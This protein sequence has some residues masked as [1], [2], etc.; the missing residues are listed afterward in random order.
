MKGW[1][2]IIIHPETTIREAMDVIDRSSV[3]IALVVDR[4]DY[5][6]GTLTDGDMRRGLLKGIDLNQPVDTIYNKSPIFGKEGNDPSNI[7]AF[8][9]KSC[10]RQLPVLDSEGRVVGF[11]LLEDFLWKHEQKTIVVLMAGGLGTR[12]RPLTETSPKPLLK[13]GD[14]PLLE[15]TLERFVEL[16]FKRF[17]VAVNYMAKM[18]EE[19]FGDGS[20]WG[21]EIGYLRE[22]KRLGTAGALSLLPERP[23]EPSIVIN[24]DLLT[25]VN[26]K[27]LLDFHEEAKTS[28]TICVRE[29]S[30]RIPFGV[31]SIE[32]QRLKDLE[33]KPTQN[34][35]VNA[36]I[37]VLEP[38]AIDLIPK[39]RFYDMTNLFEELTRLG[40]NPAVFPLREYWLDIGQMV[41]Y[42]Q[43]NHEY[44]TS[45]K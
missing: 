22:D 20:R 16:G 32:K 11:E 7:Q 21:V 45:K 18:I 40:N 14:K 24:G 19:H 28:A 29:Y 15:I 36:G 33:E 26:F 27:N 8:M 39:E 31:V 34:F 6:L 5:L 4:D 41:D 43:A 37:Y 12:L 30:L 35:F 9:K 10:V 13:V 23:N 25:D 44:C 38:E 17:Y 2:Q 42:Q 1:R 3:Q